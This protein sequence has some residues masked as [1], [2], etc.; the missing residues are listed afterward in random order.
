MLSRTRILV[1]SLSMNLLVT[2]G[3]GFIGS[4]VIRQL[5]RRSEPTRIVN[6]P[7]RSWSVSGVPSGVVAVSRRIVGFM[8]VAQVVGQLAP[9]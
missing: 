2:G 4:N 3:A 5:L 9:K 7:S 8:A 6:M 1:P